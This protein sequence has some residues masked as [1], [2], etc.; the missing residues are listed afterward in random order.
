[1]HSALAYVE[2]LQ[3]AGCWKEAED[4]AEEVLQEVPD[5]VED[6]GVRAWVR[7]VAAAARLEHALAE[8]A[9]NDVAQALHDWNAAVD[10]LESVRA[11]Q[12][13]PWEMLP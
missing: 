10:D 4:L 8:D 6:R 5:T 1:V 3:Y 13:S 2:V 11:E 12:K 7:S 9:A